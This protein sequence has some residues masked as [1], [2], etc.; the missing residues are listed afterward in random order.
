MTPAIARIVECPYCG[1]TKELMRLASGNTFRSKYWSDQKMEAPMLPQVSPVQKCPHCGKYYLEFKQKGRDGDD[2]S[3]ELGTLS[4]PEWKE[5]YY[6]LLEETENSDECKQVTVEDL[7]YIHYLLVQAY[8]DYYYR[9]A[10]AE[11]SAEEYAFIQ[12]IIR[13]L[14][15]S[16][17]WS[18]ADTLLKAE[19]YREANMIQECAT[20]LASI[21][22]ATLNDVGKQVYEG[23]KARIERGETQVFEIIQ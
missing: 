22:P 9:E 14:I 6:Q 3:F 19:L 10:V 21:D 4:Y 13:D 5:A 8:N 12:G 2:Y 15:D 23:I 16:M 18:Q 20:V 17:D 11:P 1:K 7:T